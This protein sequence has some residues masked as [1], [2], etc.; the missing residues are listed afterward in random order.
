MRD[1]KGF[2]LPF[3]FFWIGCYAKA[4]KPC[5]PYFLPIAGGRIVGFIPFPRVLALHGMQRASSCILNSDHRVLSLN[6][7]HYIES[8]S[9]AYMY[10]CM[11]VCMYV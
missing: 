2:N 11:Y 7:I 6:E 10:V 1:L 3:S 5:V 8:A 9:Y 4:K